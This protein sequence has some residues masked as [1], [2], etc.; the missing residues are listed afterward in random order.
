[1]GLR[2]ETASGAIYEFVDHLTRVRRSHSAAPMRKDGVWLRCQRVSMM[3]GRPM[4]LHLLGVAAEGVT[5][6]T[7]TPVVSIES[8]DEVHRDMLGREDEWHH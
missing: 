4:T 8:F 1:M 7:T 3:Y 2:V 6:R 5:V